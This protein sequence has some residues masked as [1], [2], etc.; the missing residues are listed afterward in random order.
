MQ[1]I[2]NDESIKLLLFLKEKEKAMQKGED[3]GND[4]LSVLFSSYRKKILMRKEKG[5]SEGV[6]TLQLALMTGPANP[7]FVNYCLERGLFYNLAMIV[8][9]YADSREDALQE[10]FVIELEKKMK[11]KNSKNILPVLCQIQAVLPDSKK[12]ELRREIEKKPEKCTM[13]GLYYV[14][15][16]Y[17]ISL[18]PSITDYFRTK[19]RKTGVITRKKAD[20]SNPLYTVIRLF[21][22]G[23]IPSV[24]MFLD[25]TADVDLINLALYPER[26]ELGE[27]G[28]AWW[29]ILT[30]QDYKKIFSNPEKQVF[31]DEIMSVDSPGFCSLKALVC[32]LRRDLAY[33]RIIEKDEKRQG[34]IS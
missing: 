9:C 12:E 24:T 32:S 14:L 8:R 19:I 10:T 18:S 16:D 13:Q 11:R 21:K 4:R 22:E 2:V 27:F 28:Q 17:F 23:C 30:P 1:Q 34:N 33:R 7:Y 29:K 3:P 26:T 25:E 6:K 20:F 5:Y 31:F 15:S